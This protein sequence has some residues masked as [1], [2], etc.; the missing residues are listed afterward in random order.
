[1]VIHIQGDNMRN[2][3]YIMVI[4]PDDYPGKKYR[5]K[6]CYEHYLV[7]WN[8]YGVIPGDDEI[9]HHRDEDK[10]HNVPENLI[11]MTRKDHSAMHDSEKLSSLVVLKCPGC[12]KIFIREKRQSFLQKSSSYTCC[13]RACIGITTSLPISEQCI[14]ISEN[15]VEEFKGKKSDYLL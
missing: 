10:H 7:Y 8:A 6:Y 13:C 15:L 14:R 11:L 1:M 2:G 4:A 12:Q 9:I 5:G 3:D